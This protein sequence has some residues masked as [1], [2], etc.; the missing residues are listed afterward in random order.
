MAV[1]TWIKLA[2][3]ISWGWITLGLIRTI[4]KPPGTYWVTVDRV[5]QVR[6]VYGVLV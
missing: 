4:V 1:S 5:V 2:L 3:N 6:V